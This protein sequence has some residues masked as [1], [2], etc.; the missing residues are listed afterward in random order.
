MGEFYMG[1]VETAEWGIPTGRCSQDI[2]RLEKATGDECSQL[3][4]CP[5]KD[6]VAYRLTPR[7][8]RVEGGLIYEEI[9]TVEIAS[10]KISADPANPKDV[11]GA[12]KPDISLLPSAALLHMTVAM[13]CGASK[14]GPYNWREKRIKARGYIAAAIRHCQQYLDG[15][16][17][18]PEENAGH[19][20]AHAMATCAIV[21]DAR[22]TGNLIDD[23]P[24]PGVAGE[25]I[26]YFN[27]NHSFE[28]FKASGTQP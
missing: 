23:R 10:A 28:G 19:H 18:D 5:L 21:L 2:C 22:E 20:L 17:F 9:P 26:R 24:A 15:E 16:D 4:P 12:K 25:M 7:E 11:A 14:Y 13:Q 27:D 8:E 3:H 6:D 1:T